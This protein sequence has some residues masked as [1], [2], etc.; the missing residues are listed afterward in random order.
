MLTDKVLS[1]HVSFF[2]CSE[3]AESGYLSHFFKVEIFTME[4]D[5]VSDS[6]VAVLVVLF[7]PC[8]IIKLQKLFENPGDISTLILSYD[9]NWSCLLFLGSGW[10]AEV[11]VQVVDLS[12]CAVNL[13]S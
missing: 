1:S 7:F 3:R 12:S 6:M 8:Q 11:G 13:I 5:S 9:N 2:H 4:R 10:H